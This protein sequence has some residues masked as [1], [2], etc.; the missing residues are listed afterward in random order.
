[1]ST[2]CAENKEIELKF[3]VIFNQY[4]HSKLDAYRWTYFHIA[5]NEFTI[6][7][8]ST[9]TIDSCV[10]EWLSTECVIVASKLS[11][12]LVVGA[13]ALTGLLRIQIDFVVDEALQ[14]ASYHLVII[15]LCML[16]STENFD[17]SFGFCGK[18]GD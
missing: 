16:V 1:M 18:C 12:Q 8:V 3:S 10:F 9:A 2:I 11:G 13:S 14:K 15:R 5:F 17:F 6:A 7:H 4:I